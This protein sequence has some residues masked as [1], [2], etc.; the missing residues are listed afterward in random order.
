MTLLLTRHAETV[1]HAE[2]RYAGISDIDLTPR[3][4]QQAQRLADWVCT[5]TVDAIV[6]SPVR[7]ARETAAPSAAATGIEIEVEDDLREVGFGIAEGRT[8]SEL[9]PDIVARFR[10]DPVAHPFPGAEQPTAAAERCAAALRRIAARHGDDRVLVVAHNTLLRLGLCALLGLPVAHYRQVF[11]RLDNV[12]VTEIA[13]PDG[14][15]GPVALLSLNVPM[16]PDRTQTAGGR[17]SS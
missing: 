16:R 8:L 13:L 3:G 2:N 17:S 6:C 15:A 7:R 1:W 4:E 12:A 10:A 14:G 5:R 9:D 11:P